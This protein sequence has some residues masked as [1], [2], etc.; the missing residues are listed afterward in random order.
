MYNKTYIDLKFIKSK[1]IN[2]ILE[3]NYQEEPD[4]EVF[5][6]ESE[7]NKLMKII[8][9]S[10]YTNKDI[11]IR[12]L[13]SNCS[14]SLNK[15]HQYKLQ[16]MESTE[17]GLY[18]IQINPDNNNKI[19]TISDNGIG[20]NKKELIENIGTIAKSDTELH[21]QKQTL[22]KN[23]DENNMIGKFGVG[24]YSVFL[25]A[26]KVQIIT[27]S[28][29]DNKYTWLWESDSVG[30][31]RITKISDND[32]LHG[33]TINVYL[34]KE[35]FDYLDIFKIRD[36]IKKH[37]QYINYTIELLVP[38]KMS[39]G[40]KKKQ[41]DYFFENDDKQNDDKQNNDNIEY[42]WEPINLDGPIWEKD[43]SLVSKN[44]YNSFYKN[45]SNDYLDYLAHKHFKVEG[46]VEFKTIIFIP[47]KPLNDIFSPH[48]NKINFHL[49][50]NRVFVMSDYDKLIPNWLSFICGIVDSSDLPLNI[51]REIL[52]E[53]TLIPLI[54]RKIIS[55]TIELISEIYENREL[56]EI[57]YQAYSKSLKFAVY[58][59]N[60]YKDKISQFLLFNTSKSKEQ[61]KS[62][63]EYI[64][65]ITDEQKY[66]F[67]ITGET[68]KYVEESIFTEVFEFQNIEVIFMTDTID[69][70]ML[71]NFHK[72]KDFELVSV[73]HEKISDYLPVQ[74]KKRDSYDILLA[75]FKEILIG[76]IE[77]V[78]I[79]QRLTQSPACIIS[80][81]DGWTPNMERIMKA[82]ALSGEGYKNYIGNQKI[83]EINIEHP[84]IIDINKCLAKDKRP[85][86]LKEKIELIFNI[87][88]L[89]SG[90]TVE[91]LPLLCKHLYGTLNF[92]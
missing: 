78:V 14:D 47:Q 23:H 31:Y 22:D 90:F 8:I 41:Q 73:Y 21:R 72:Y 92:E 35:S 87:S 58:E 9:N 54:S 3:M 24:F 36:I 42:T 32:I 2:K 51:S 43:P 75:T 46:P 53:N 17:P 49:Y 44:E 45:I 65:N 34:K 63:D 80:S 6:F 79:S 88:C 57:F 52:Q 84:L 68:F 20:M 48:K 11:F 64:N 16:Q 81:K 56:K 26:D 74:N 77:K 70:Y 33:C 67:Y 1:Y 89:S 4:S 18:K 10:F 13:I 38:N 28:Y 83:M 50:S 76:K 12:E 66:I 71:Q 39:K 86:D 91:N 7:T 29:Y 60:D 69:E 55:K 27:R 37:S 15:L 61:L 30:S 19:L 62:L 5:P 82:Q 25:V 85:S 59:N 40:D